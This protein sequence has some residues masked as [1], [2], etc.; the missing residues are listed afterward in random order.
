MATIRVRSGKTIEERLR[1]Y[2]NRLSWS[3]G[4]PGIGYHANSSYWDG[5]T[6]MIEMW[7]RMGFVVRRPG[8]T[9]AGR[10]KGIPDQLFVEVGR[11]N[12][13][14]RINWTPENGALPR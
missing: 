6:H 3:R 8:P 13:E 4:V 1:F 5:I 11:A 9:D 2:N 12:M 10:P 14:T 7:Q